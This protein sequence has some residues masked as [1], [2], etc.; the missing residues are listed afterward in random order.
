MQTRT[1]HLGTLL[2]LLAFAAPLTLSAQVIQQDQKRNGEK[3]RERY[4]DKRHKDYHEWD[5]SEDRSF[6]LYLNNKQ[7][8][9]VEFRLQNVREQQRYWAWRHSHSDDDNR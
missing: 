9:F 4:Y 5:D 3:V 7:R 2:F 6:R 8:P 1:L